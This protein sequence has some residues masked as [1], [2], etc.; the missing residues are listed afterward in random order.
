VSARRLKPNYATEPEFADSL[1]DEQK[2]K[3]VLDMVDDLTHLPMGHFYERVHKA[4]L[5][6]NENGMYGHMPRLW[7]QYGG[8]DLGETVCER[9]I[10]SANNV[11]PTASAW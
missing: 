7:R 8:K 2:A 11:S 10:S 3:P 6:R 5:V 9:V 4:D 1:S